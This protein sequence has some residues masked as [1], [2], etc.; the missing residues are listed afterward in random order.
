MQRRP[1]NGAGDDFEPH[2]SRQTRATRFCRDPALLGGRRR[3]DVDLSDNTNQWGVPPAAAA[4]LREG[5]DVSRYPDMYGDSLKRTIAKHGGHRSRVRRDRQRIRRFARLRDSRVRVP[6]RHRR[7][8]RPDVR[9]APGILAHQRH[10]AGAGPLATDFSMDADALLATNARIIYLC[11]PN[12]PTASPTSVDTHPAHHRRR[13]RPGADR[14]G[15]RGVHRAAGI[16][17]R[18]A[19]AR[20]RGRVPHHVEGVRTCG[21]ARG[22]RRGVAESHRDDREVA[23]TVQAQHAGR[24][25]SRGRADG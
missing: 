9:H 25:R 17:R 16:P 20:T 8:S 12:N 19:G 1:D 24:T 10:H 21:A 2:R 14:R 4:A 23:R 15:I 22:L 3:R 13:A 5:L 6:G 7:A 18:S 11:S